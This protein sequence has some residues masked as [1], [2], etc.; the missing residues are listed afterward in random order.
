MRRRPPRVRI[1][2]PLVQ[3]VDGFGRA[4]LDQGYTPLS[5]RSQL[6]LMA[7]VSRWLAESELGAES[8][9]P[10]RVDEFLAARRG[11]GH[12]HLLSPRGVAPLL[13]H[14]RGLGVTP[15]AASEPVNAVERLLTDYARFL[16][17]ERG[18]AGAT[19]QRYV[20]FAR[21][22]VA[23]RAGTDGEVDLAAMSP[24]EVTQF[25]LREC[26]ERVPGSAKCGLTRLRSLLRFLHVEGRAP[27]LAWAVPSGPSWRLASLPKGI[28]RR[29]VTALLASC[30]RRTAV[31]RRDFAILTMLVRLGL[32]CGEV[33][34][35]ELADL[36]WRAGEILV[37]G[38]GSRE[39]RLPLPVDVGEAVAGWLRRG[40]PRCGCTK[41]F[42]RVLAPHRG[43]TSSA[44]SSVVV[45]A[46]VRAG[47]PPIGAH[48]LRHTAATEM[49]RAGVGL[50]EVGQVL[51]HRS[52]LSTS[53]YAK[54]DLAALSELARPWPGG[55]DQ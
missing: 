10:A 17:R 54:V 12:T 49:L 25:V 9:T 6:E 33:A 36:D 46:A 45:S 47:L 14:L 35:L 52:A 5:A 13:A 42:T 3:Y 7:H 16:V 19:V 27:E 1:T 53:L 4:L 30:D 44:V 37:R 43:L 15:I 48:R 40:R 39:E 24:E 32:R 20:G 2:G 50:A 22:F 55:E 29:Q 38:K 34:N 28:D 23:Q 31:G 41:V 8:L 21:R 18:F 11:E 51:R 26:S